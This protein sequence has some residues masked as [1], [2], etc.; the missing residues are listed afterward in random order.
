MYLLAVDAMKEPAKAEPIRVKFEGHFRVPNCALFNSKGN[1]TG[2]G[3]LARRRYNNIKRGNDL[4]QTYFFEKFKMQLQ[5]DEVC[6]F[7]YSFCFS[8]K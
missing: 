4:I 5:H 8:A 2:F 1:M 7:M 6:H 3:L